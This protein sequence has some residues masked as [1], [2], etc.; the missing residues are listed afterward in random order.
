M[1]QT[2]LLLLHT[3]QVAG[4]VHHEHER[5]VVSVADVDKPRTLV[6]GVGVDAAG[7]VHGVVRHE[8]DRAAV[9]TPERADQV[10]GVVGLDLHDVLVIAELDQQVHHVV[11]GVGV[12]RHEGVEVGVVELVV[13]RRPRHRGLVES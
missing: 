3:W 10:L 6:R 4:G 2:H 5:N 12:V 1:D 11:A 8:T 9:D 7:V 13:G